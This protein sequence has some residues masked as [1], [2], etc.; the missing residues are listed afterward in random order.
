MSAS[1]KDSIPTLQATSKVLLPGMKQVRSLLDVSIRVLE[2]F[3]THAAR[4]PAGGAVTPMKRP[5]AI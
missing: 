3:A 1:P 4:E 2:Y 5:S